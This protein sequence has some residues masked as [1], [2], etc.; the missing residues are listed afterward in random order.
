MWAILGLVIAL[1]VAYF[2]WVNV[3]APTSAE[4]KRQLDEGE[5]LPGNPLDDEAPDDLQ[6]ESLAM[7][8]FDYED[9]RG[10]RSHRTVSVSAV[11]GEYFEG[12]CH[13][14]LETRTFVIGRV[15]G[16]VTVT[17][18]GEVLTARE[19]A[20]DARR[21]PRNGCV[22]MDGPP[23]IAEEADDEVGAIETDGIEILFTG[24]GKDQRAQ[25]EELAEDFGMTVRKSVTQGL[26]Y[27]CAGPNA[28]PAKLAQALEAG[29][30][31]IDSDELFAL[32]K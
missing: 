18:T 21:D 12:F 14:A 27:V 6:G 2:I 4:L 7:I 9:A 1:A 24:F 30:A 25:M 5:A 17:D 29:V 26:D 19:W 11:D 31:V 15:R 22:T 8:E 13:T 16:K 3:S 32:L 23:Q 10:R 20:A 28:G